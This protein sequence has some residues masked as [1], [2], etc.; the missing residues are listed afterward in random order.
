MV[1]AE[2]FGEES[3]RLIPGE[4]EVWAPYLLAPCAEFSPQGAASS[5]LLPDNSVYTWESIPIHTMT[6]SSINDSTD[7]TGGREKI[8]VLNRCIAKRVITRK[9]RKRENR[10]H[11]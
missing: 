3:A 4:P 10:S 9:G 11:C 7:V 1:L 6:D 8:R 2:V 5:T